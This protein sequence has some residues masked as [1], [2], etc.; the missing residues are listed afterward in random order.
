MADSGD[1]Q[2]NRAAQA[3]L[4]KASIRKTSRALKAHPPNAKPRPNPKR[5]KPLPT[6]HLL[7]T[8]KNISAASVAHM[9]RRKKSNET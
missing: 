8:K 6:Q 1:I 7:P 4:Q 5:N 3:E 2:T 9:R